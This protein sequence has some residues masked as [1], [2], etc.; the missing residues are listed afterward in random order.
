[1]RYVFSRRATGKTFTCVEWLSQG[2][3][4]M[5][6]PFWNRIL[7]TF[8]AAERERLIKTYNLNPRQVFTWQ[9]WHHA[10]SLGQLDVEL[11]FDNVDLILRNIARGC[12]IKYA[13][14][15]IN[16]YDEVS[17]EMQE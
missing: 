13:T 8:S 1:M 17:Q 9:D 16:P 3:Q 12:P 5:R 6:W 10:K 11:A 14:F 7:I 2:V 4:G 15:N